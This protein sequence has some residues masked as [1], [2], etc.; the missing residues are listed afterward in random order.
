[1]KERELDFRTPYERVADE[2]AAAASAEILAMA[3]SARRSI[4]QL[5][6]ADH[7]R[8]RVKAD[9]AKK[10]QSTTRS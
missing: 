8:R 2:R 3:E 4:G 1:V 7:W 6:R 5:T 9:L 10:I